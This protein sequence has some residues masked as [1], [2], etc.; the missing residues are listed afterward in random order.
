MLSGISLTTL[1]GLTERDGRIAVGYRE[2]P[3]KLPLTHRQRALWKRHRPDHLSP[4][5][6]GL[7]LTATSS[8]PRAFGEV[9]QT[10]PGDMPLRPIPLSRTVIT[11]SSTVLTPH[12]RIG[13][14]RVSH[15]VRQRLPH[16]RDDIGLEFERDLAGAALEGEIREESEAFPCLLDQGL[17]LWARPPSGIGWLSSKMACRMSLT[18]ASRSATAASSLVA[19]RPSVTR[20]AACSDSPAAYNR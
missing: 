7:H 1:R 16:H 20:P 19:D 18:A 14:L 11:R 3:S 13:G 9:R 4:G 17:Q 12:L 6:H 10:T 2:S 8:G 5:V 15:A